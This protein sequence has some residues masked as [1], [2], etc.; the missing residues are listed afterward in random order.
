[1]F[2]ESNNKKWHTIIQERVFYIFHIQGVSE[3]MQ[4]LITFTKIL[5]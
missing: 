5:F 1:M 3:N 4:Q 2:A